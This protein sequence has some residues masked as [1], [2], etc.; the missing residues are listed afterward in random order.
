MTRFLRIP[1][2]IPAGA[3]AAALVASSLAGCR[4]EAPHITVHTEKGASPA[5]MVVT[6]TATLQVSP[7]CADLTMTLSARAP[8]P[9]AAVEQVRGRQD[10]LIAAL[11]KLGVEDGD[12]K[13]STLSVLPEQEWIEQRPVFKGYSARITIIATTHKFDQLGALM[14]AGAAAGVTEM[15]SQFRRSDLDKLKKQV[16][17]QALVAARDKARQNASVLGIEL[18]RVTG[19]AEQSNSYLYANAYFPRVANSVETAGAPSGPSIGGE[20][21]P[22]TLDVTVTYDLPEHG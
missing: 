15:A 11:R 12:L 7:D 6:G 10:A 18:G 13:L 22:L 9:G 19:V 4:A 17:E 16:R 2:L 20:L 5:Q 1:R 14:E 21:Q 3:L 8:R